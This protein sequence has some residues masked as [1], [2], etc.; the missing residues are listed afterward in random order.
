MAEERITDI[1]T[2]IEGQKVSRFLLTVICISWIVTFFDA[3]D[4]NVIAYA[5]P[6]F[7]PAFHF[8][9][10]MVGNVFSAGLSGT[11]LGAF[12]FGFIGDKIGRRRA[13]LLAAAWFSIMTLAFTLAGSYRAM[14]ILRFLTGTAT[15]GFLPLIWALNIE[16]APKRFRSTLV[17]L[18]MLGYASG[19]ILCGPISIAL[20]P[21]F[22]WRAVFLFGGSLTLSG[23]GLLAAFL[24]ESIRF[25]ASQHQ[26][27]RKLPAS[28]AVL[29]AAVLRQT[30][31]LC[32]GMRPDRAN[33]SSRVC[34][35]PV[36]CATS[37]RC[38][39]WPTSAVP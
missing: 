13:I 16:Y 11:I 21:R 4:L 34:C 18:N 20:I 9:K 38:S 22:G 15:G 33:A 5:A 7:V 14:L 28:S 6:Y 25:L 23:T 32:L 10:M 27:P 39:G 1:S 2:I 36:S 31:H 19:A 24:P 3:F 37:H 26:R 35:S 12:F 8:S 29:P 17:T 30:Q